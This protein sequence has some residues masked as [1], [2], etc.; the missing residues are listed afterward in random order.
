MSER[1]SLEE[2]ISQK[3]DGNKK[4]KDVSIHSDLC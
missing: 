3:H 4:M 2:Y 1:L